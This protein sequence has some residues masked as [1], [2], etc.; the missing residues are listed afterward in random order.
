MQYIV[1][2]ARRL[3]SHVQTGELRTKVAARGVRTWWTESKHEMTT[4]TVGHEHTCD[5][6]LVLSVRRRHVGRACAPS[7]SRERVDLSY[8]IWYHGAVIWARDHTPISFSLRR[9]QLAP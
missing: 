5:Q 7:D 4:A 2:R 1:K 6:H 3:E 9:G 8:R